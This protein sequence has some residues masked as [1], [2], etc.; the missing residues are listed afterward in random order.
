MKFRI[1]LSGKLPKL[2]MQALII[3]KT[4]K[5]KAKIKTK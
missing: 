3:P 5:N 1:H 4:K 2:V